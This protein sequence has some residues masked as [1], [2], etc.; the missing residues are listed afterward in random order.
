MDGADQPEK[1]AAPVDLLVEGEERA[2][3]SD[4]P[5]RQNPQPNWPKMAAKATSVANMA[6]ARMPKCFRSLMT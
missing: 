2:Q 5:A 3:A 4:I 1:E 6:A